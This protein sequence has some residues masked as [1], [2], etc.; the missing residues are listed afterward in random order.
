MRPHRHVARLNMGRQYECHG[1]DIALLFAPAFEGEAHG[2]G[3]GHVTRQRRTSTWRSPPSASSRCIF[4]NAC[5]IERSANHRSYAAQGINL[6]PQNKIG[7][8]GA[9]REERGE[10]AERAAEHR[11]IAW[12]NGEKLLAEPEIAL[13]AL[14]Q[15]HSTF[16]RQA[17]ARFVNR[18]TDGGSSL[19]R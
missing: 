13:W 9:R 12:D 10:Q 17:L 7:P 19:P 18:H 11:K 14:T 6:V 2:V 16:T 15:Q 5:S 4:A 3:M 1:R 8:A